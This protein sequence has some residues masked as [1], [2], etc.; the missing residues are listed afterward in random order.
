[1]IRKVKPIDAEQICNIYNHYVE[2]TIITFE[3]DPVPTSEMTNR[4]NE[5]SDKLP[6]FVYEQDSEVIGYAYAS[7]WKGRCAY[8]YTS[9]V[10]VYVAHNS[11]GKGIGSA[12]YSHL[13]TELKANGLHVAIGG[14]SLPNE[15]SKALHEKFGF[16][17]VAHF[18]QV[19]FKFDKWI[20][21]GYWQKVL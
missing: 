14:I 11:K 15:Q 16:E 5:A 1:M 21:V 8:Q 9:E 4:I 13:L 19:G 10:S 3:I 2:N 7:K 20:D 17:Q 18:R 6:W 12:L